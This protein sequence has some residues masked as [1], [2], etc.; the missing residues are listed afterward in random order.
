[1]PNKNYYMFDRKDVFFYINLGTYAAPIWTLVMNADEIASDITKTEIEVVN[2]VS[3]FK[4][5]RSG[6]FD[7]PLNFKYSRAAIDIT[8]TIYDALY[9]DSFV[10]R[11][12]FEM[13]LTV[14]PITDPMAG[15]RAYF[16][17]M[18]HNFM[19][20]SEGQQV[21]DLGMKLTDVCENDAFIE[22]ELLVPTT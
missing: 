19:K 1:M 8:D 22:P 16:E 15:F 7:L 2:G 3:Q 20:K 13:A 4:L 17:V 10:G 5:Y 18:K 21:Y 6:K 14:G 12:P 11:E 9:T